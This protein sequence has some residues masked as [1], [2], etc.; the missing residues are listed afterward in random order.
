[1]ELVL[2]GIGTIAEKTLKKINSKPSLIVDNNPGTWGQIFAGVEVQS[3]DILKS[4]SN[5]QILICTTSYKDVVNQLSDYGISN[6]QVSPVLKNVVEIDRIEDLA[7]DLLFVSGLPSTEKEL[8]GG[9]VFRVF[10][11]FNSYSVDKIEAGNCHG[12]T[13]NKSNSDEIFV[14]DTSRGL[15]VLNRNNLSIKREINYDLALRPHGIYVKSSSEIYLACSYED[16]IYQIDQ[17][18]NNIAKFSIANLSDKQDGDMA[19]HHINDMT[20]YEGN[21]YASMFSATGSWQQGFLDG[22]IKKINLETGHVSTIYN[23][24]QMPHNIQVDHTGMKFCNSLTGE[25]CINNRQVVF[26]GNGFV[27]G[28]YDSGDYF[29]IGESKNRNFASIKSPI[30]NN[31]LDTRLNFVDKATLAYKSIQLPVEIS[32]IHAIQD[33]KD[34]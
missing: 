25:L 33:L 5:I 9:G 8:S 2:F 24:L 10:G 12:I 16:A 7:F 29:I 19:Q 32:E 30:L 20:L 15:L 3:P 27:R 18:G 6:F 34:V 26:K 1:M 14:T 23:D 4:K 31:C 11:S 17:D 21:L 28:L 13:I 22:A